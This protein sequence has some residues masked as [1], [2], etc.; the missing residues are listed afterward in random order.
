[1]TGC[2]FGFMLSASYTMFNIYF[3]EKRVMMMS[4]AQSFFGLGSMAL[5]I[6]VNFLLNEYGFRGCMAI[7]AALNAHVI[8]AMLL[9]HPLEWH[10]IITEEIS[11]CINI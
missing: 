4:Y 6:L 11:N 3:I 7:I 10:F 2:G 8:F 5:P 9:M 1:M